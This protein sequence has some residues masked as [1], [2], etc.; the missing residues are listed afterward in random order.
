VAEVSLEL[1]Q[2]LAELGRYEQAAATFE[3]ALSIAFELGKAQVAVKLTRQLAHVYGVGLDQFDR[4]RVLAN[5]GL[6][7]ARKLDDS[8]LEGGMHNALSDACRRKGQFA[9]GEAHARLAVELLERA[10]AAEHHVVGL[11]RNTLG[12]HLEQ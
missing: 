2:A 4:A 11:A 7:L 3:G 5:I 10:R 12:T 8:G 9:E 1:G 6:G